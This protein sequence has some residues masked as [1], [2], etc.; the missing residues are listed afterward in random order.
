MDS[1]WEVGGEGMAFNI[2]AFDMNKDS[3]LDIVVGN[4]NDTYVYFA[5]SMLD[6]F[7][8]ITYIGRM[9]A[10]CDYN[11]D[12]FDDLIAMHYTNYDSARYDYDGEILFYWGSDTTGLAIDTIAD[13]SIPL[14]TLHPY[15]ERFTVGGLMVGV[16]KGDLNG[17][18]KVDLVFSSTHGVDSAGNIRSTGNIYIYIWERKRQQIQRI[19]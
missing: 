1:F 8:D 17:D 6:T 10:V 2:E 19:M 14:P 5:G 9:L 12:G 3:N 16:Q 18:G 11:G 15:F 4:W 13:Y 7:V